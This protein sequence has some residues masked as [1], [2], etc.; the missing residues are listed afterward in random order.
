[1]K[2]KHLIWMAP[3]A[4]V[5]L[6]LV[7]L[8]ISDLMYNHKL[9]ANYHTI[10]RGDDIAR[11]TSLLGDSRAICSSQE[12]GSANETIDSFIYYQRRSLRFIADIA[13]SFLSIESDPKKSMSKKCYK[14]NFDASGK[15]KDV[16]TYDP[17]DYL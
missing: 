3:L 7:G 4:L 1:M 14:V 5:I 9:E 13:L 16:T 2:S 6:A 11:V 10:K 8:H 12:I 15:V 17:R